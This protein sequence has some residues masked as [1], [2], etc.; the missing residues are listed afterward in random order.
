MA[1]SII[2]L[3]EAFYW[4]KP[5]AKKAGMAT[6]YFILGT[7]G[8]NTKSATGYTCTYHLET[9]LPQIQITKNNK[10]KQLYYEAIFQLEGSIRLQLY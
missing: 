8:Q 10:L 9:M 4:M 5:L 6:V 7:F 3:T 2:P 1:E